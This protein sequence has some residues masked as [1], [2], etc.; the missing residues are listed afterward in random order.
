MGLCRGP[1]IGHTA[2]PLP[3][4]KK[5]LGKEKPSAKC[6]KKPEKNSKMILFF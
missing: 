4:A 5:T 3:R 6:K 2:K 1:F